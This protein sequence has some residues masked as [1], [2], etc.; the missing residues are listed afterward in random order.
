MSL[1]NAIH[2]YWN[3]RAELTEEVPYARFYTGEVP[4]ETVPRP[5][6]VLA[7]SKESERDSS[8]VV[9]E[10]YTVT[11]TAI[12]DNSIDAETICQL[13]EKT[14]DDA[15]CKDSMTMDGNDELLA[16]YWLNTEISEPQPGLWQG[17]VTYR[18]QVG[19]LLESPTT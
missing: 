8:N 7:Y 4:E 15:I 14:F 17:V 16:S 11:F 6:L 1:P 12:C 9:I 18:F 2:R 19:T 5:Y 10:N 13:I 3:N